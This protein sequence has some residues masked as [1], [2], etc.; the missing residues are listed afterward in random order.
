MASIPKLF[1]LV[2]KV[3]KRRKQVHSTRDTKWIEVWIVVL[4][5]GCKREDTS[6]QYPWKPTWWISRA[7]HSLYIDPHFLCEIE[8]LDSIPYIHL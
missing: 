5:I 8:P 6:L 3:S 2:G 7:L 1:F 4:C